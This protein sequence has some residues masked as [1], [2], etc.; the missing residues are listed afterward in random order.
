[1]AFI[2]S[3]SL[4]AKRY[5]IKCFTFCLSIEITSNVDAIL[6]LIPKHTEGNYLKVLHTCCQIRFSKI[7]KSNQISTKKKELL[8]I[9]KAGFLFTWKEYSIE[10]FKFR[11]FWLNFIML[12][13][14][15]FQ[16]NR[17]EFIH[18]IF[19]RINSNFFIHW[20]P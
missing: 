20:E 1:M 14:R 5:L 8:R 17:N 12:K 15:I 10:K 9:K 3:M 11:D 7:E 13:I 16:T 19:K 6:A 2:I 18:L 4:W